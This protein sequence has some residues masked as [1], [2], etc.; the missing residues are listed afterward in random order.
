MVTETAGREAGTDAGLEAAR[1][2]VRE[3]M[4]LED[5]QAA[6]PWLFW[7]PH[8]FRDDGVTPSGQLQFHQSTHV[9]RF[10]WPGNGWG[11][12]SCASVEVA[13]WIYH[14]HPYQRTPAWPVTVIWCCETY[15]QFDL[16]RQQLETE[17]LGPERSLR[18]PGGWKFN[19]SKQCYV[20][21]DGS[22]LYLVS[23]DGSWTHVQGVPCDLV[24][25]DE[26][27]PWGL[28]NELTQRRRAKRKTR[29]IIAATATQGMTWMY[30]KL[31]APWLK[32]YAERG[33]TLDQAIV[34]QTHP[35]TWVWERG[36][37]DDNPAADAEDRAYYRMKSYGSEAE[38][39]V[40]LHGGFLDFSGRPVFDLEALEAMRP[41]LEDG[42]TGSLVRVLKEDGRTPIRGKYRFI[43][44]G[45]GDRGRV[46]IFRHP[47]ADRRY[48]VSHDSAWGLEDKDFD[49]ATVWDRLTGEQVAEAQGRWGDDTWVDVLE[50]LHYYYY[51]A[52][53]C[54]EKQVGLFAMRAL[55]DKRGITYQYYNRDEAKRARRRSDTLG[56][57]RHAGDLVIKFARVALSG[58][59]V[60]GVKQPPSITI[61]SRELHRQCR[62]YQFRATSSARTY[63]EILQ[64]SQLTTGAPSG[65]HDDGV[66][67]M[68]YGV[69]GMR[70]V[71]SFHD[72]EPAYEPGTVGEDMH[73]ILVEEPAQERRRRAFSRGGG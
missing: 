20:W 3:Q 17:A 62:L 43:A 49:Y 9:N 72:D 2:R 38:K 26:E 19:Q 73:H 23:G 33:M 37:I 61:R 14:C 66:M 12:T 16:L 41:G 32:W 52:F 28:F 25:F 22:R 57:F 36:G 34:M 64:S 53:L 45:P 31:F 50:A 6:Q 27:P 42:E 54:G 35:L 10:L 4:L 63:E 18:H 8:Q 55:Y 60:N 40:R 58:E 47:R 39:T 68:V 24:V 30:H 29:Y 67:S 46:T 7:R 69:L 15:K 5:L 1:G 13:W 11:K 59:L 70:E 21:P 51:G 65:D 44:D 71:G 56:Y 48:V